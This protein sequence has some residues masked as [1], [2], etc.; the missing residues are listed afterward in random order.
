MLK[1]ERDKNQLLQ[2]STRDNIET[3]TNSC[4]QTCDLLQLSYTVVGIVMEKNLENNKYT[5]LRNKVLG[6]IY[7]PFVREWYSM[8]KTEAKHL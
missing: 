3:L 6:C 7:H 8:K 4:K 1:L 5:A 2:V